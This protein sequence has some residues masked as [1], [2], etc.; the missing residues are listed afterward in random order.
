MSAEI[1][2]PETEDITIPVDDRYYIFLLEGCPEDIDLPNKSPHTLVW[3]YVPRRILPRLVTLGLIRQGMECGPRGD[4]RFLLNGEFV[5]TDD[6]WGIRS[7]VIEN[8]DY[9]EGGEG[10]LEDPYYLLFQYGSPTE[11]DLDT[12]YYWFS[13]NWERDHEPGTQF[14]KVTRSI[15]SIEISFKHVRRS[16]RNEIRGDFRFRIHPRSQCI[17]D[18]KQE[19]NVI[20]NQQIPIAGRGTR[21][22][23]YELHIWFTDQL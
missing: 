6:E 12:N 8:R 18:Y 15:P 17:H 11:P 19:G 3:S 10:T 1:S 23:P 2:E 7:C 22:E 20:L 4:Y 21:E 5:E 16:V 13:I 9:F 14:G